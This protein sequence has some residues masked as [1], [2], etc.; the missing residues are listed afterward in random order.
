MAGKTSG[1]VNLSAAKTAKKGREKPEVNGVRPICEAN[2]AWANA[3]YMFTPSK[4]RE[5]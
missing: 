1:N 3:S 2:L 5:L 4:G